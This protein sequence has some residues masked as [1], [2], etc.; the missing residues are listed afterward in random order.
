M[1]WLSMLFIGPWAASYKYAHSAKQTSLLMLA[2]LKN[3]IEKMKGLTKIFKI[4]KIGKMLVRLIHIF[5]LFI[6]TFILVKLSVVGVIDT[7]PNTIFRRV[8]Y[9]TGWAC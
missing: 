2:H 9:E 1:L 6:K 4:N 8:S 5:R 7:E 3:K